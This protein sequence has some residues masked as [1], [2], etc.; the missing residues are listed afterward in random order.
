MSISVKVRFWKKVNK[1]GPIHPVLGQCWIW[2]SVK[3]GIEYEMLSLKRGQEYLAHRISWNI[4]FGEIPTGIRVLHKCD[5]PKCVNPNHLFLGNQQ[6]NMNDMKKKGR[7]LKGEK[8]PKH[9]LTK[10][11]VLR[12]RKMY[13]N[14]KHTQQE[15][16]NKFNIN[17]TNVGF[18][19]RRVT[20]THI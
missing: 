17:Q 7:S 19:I 4:H 5:N 10:T 13:A 8:S 14:K 6:D 3:G 12:I 2:T 11:K 1:R 9:K 15:I 16:T 20:W 18:I